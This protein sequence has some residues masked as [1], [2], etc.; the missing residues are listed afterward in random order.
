MKN[1]KFQCWQDLY[2]DGLL[3]DRCEDFCED[4]QTIVRFIHS[5]G[6]DYTY[7]YYNYEKENDDI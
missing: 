1:Q 3:D 5:N 2:Y 4:T 7:R 6:W